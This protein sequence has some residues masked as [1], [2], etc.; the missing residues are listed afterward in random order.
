MGPDG[1]DLGCAKVV[2]PEVLGGHW[3]IVGKV[4]I[5]VV[6]AD[7]VGDPWPIQEYPVEVLGLW[8]SA[9]AELHQALCPAEWK[10]DLDQKPSA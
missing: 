6:R 5:D 3:P 8:P 10:S 1:V 4:A 9:T 2:G 7:P